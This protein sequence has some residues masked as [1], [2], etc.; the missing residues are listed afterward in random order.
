MVECS[1]KTCP[2]Q[3]DLDALKARA[4]QHPAMRAL[5]QPYLST[6]DLVMAVAW[7]LS[8]EMQQ[9]PMPGFNPALILGLM[10]ADLPENDVDSRLS[11]A[12]VPEGKA[13]LLHGCKG[14]CKGKSCSGCLTPHSQ[15]MPC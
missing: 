13:Q 4:R 1:A 2:L 9:R 11:R 7:M 12:L 14:S 8:C 15:H 5:Q 6:N 3:E 10:V